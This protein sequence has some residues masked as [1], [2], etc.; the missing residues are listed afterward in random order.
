MFPRFSRLDAPDALST[1]V[2]VA[3]NKAAA[4]LILEDCQ[5]LF[6]G[7]SGVRIV[8]A[9]QAGSA[10]LRCFI[11]HVIGI[12]SKKQMVGVDAG[13]RVASMQHVHPERDRTLLDFPYKTMRFLAFA[14]HSKPRVSPF[15]GG[16][17]AKVTAGKSLWDRVV[18][19]SLLDRPV[20]RG[21]EFLSQ[22][23][24]RMA[25]TVRAGV[26]ASTLP[27]SLY[28]TPKLGV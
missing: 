15:I 18:I 23:R 14:V 17:P 19:Q 10:A 11:S 12:R 27:G 26:S 20:V 13:W 24:L 5:H 4:A 9:L 8:R 25:V 2:V 6:T 7:Q 22:D 21:F 28:F 1:D 3:S 16:R